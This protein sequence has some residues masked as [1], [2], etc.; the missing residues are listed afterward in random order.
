M[1][2]INAKSSRIWLQSACLLLFLLA[3]ISFRLK[4]S[5]S[6][7]CQ[8][9]QF[10]PL[11]AMKVPTRAFWPDRFLW[12]SPVRQTKPLQVSLCFL[13]QFWGATL[14]LTCWLSGLDLL[15]MSVA[16][17]LWCSCS[18]THVFLKVWEVICPFL[19]LWHSQASLNPRA[20]RLAA[21][22][23][24]SRR[25]PACVFKRPVFKLPD[26][27]LWSLG[28]LMAF[29]RVSNFTSHIISGSISTW[30]Y[31]VISTS[32]SNLY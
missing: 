18:W 26:S 12:W 21:L 5:F 3:K 7:S 25:P 27:S 29:C 31:L 22:S 14:F 13:L 16:A 24:L 15:W 6:I 4:N 28:L 10:Y 9:V 23:M 17:V 11:R 19:L 1:L 8:V 30:F 2:A 20:A 32:L